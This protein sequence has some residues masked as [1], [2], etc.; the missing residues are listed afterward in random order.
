MVRIFIDSANS[1]TGKALVEELSALGDLSV[2]LDPTQPSLEVEGLTVI[3]AEDSIAM[4]Q[5]LLEHDVLVFDLH[6]TPYK[7]LENS[8]KFLKA[9]ELQSTKVF[10]CIS[11]VMVWGATK[12]KVGLAEGE[13]AEQPED[14]Q[15]EEGASNPL[16]G[17]QPYTDK[18]FSL[19]KAAGRFQQWK[20]LE[21]LLISIGMSRPS[22]KLYVMAAG[23]MYGLG[24]QIL[25]YHFQSAWLEDPMQLPYIGQGDNV[26]PTIHI[27]DLARACK[28]VAESKPE[29]R[30]IIAVDCTAL[31][32]QRNIV[33]SISKGVGTGQVMSCENSAEDWGEYLSMHTYLTTSTVLLELPK[34]EEEE[35]EEQDEEG[36]VKVPFDWHCKLGIPGNISVLNQEFVE[37]RGLVPVKVIVSGPPASGK[38]KFAKKLASFYNVPRISVKD[39]VREVKEAQTDLGTR[40]R[41]R[42]QELVDELQEAAE[43]D[44]VVNPQS[45]RIPDDLLAEAFRVR[46]QANQCRNRGYILDGWPRSYSDAKNLLKPKLTT[47]D[48]EDNEVEKEDLLTDILP[49]SLIVLEASD[50]FLTARVRDSSEAQL[51]NTHFNEVDMPVRLAKYRDNNHNARGLP[52]LEDF[53]TSHG[54]ESCVL[55]CEESSVQFQFEAMKIF[56]ERTG[57]PRN[58]MAFED[59]AEQERQTR[60]AAEEMKRAAQLQFEL[61]VEE[62]LEHERKS[63][64]LAS[65][66]IRLDEHWRRNRELLEQRAQPTRAYIAEEVLPTLTEGLLEACRKLPENPVMFLAEYLFANSH[67]VKK[68]NPSSL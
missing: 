28:F 44:V 36:K 61:E 7:R 14:D 64:N 5:A 13:E 1:Y 11:S 52:S 42:L 47:T 4:S 34:S 27:I 66:Q 50:E 46:L 59:L 49:Q 29:Q 20:S 15:E 57:K 45:V 63:K 17:L 10:I 8:A 25:N 26:V 67:R 2:T 9:Q 30:Y 58:Y 43:E 21:T 54:I 32:T 37:T 16:K 40:V 3:D 23:L 24:E 62:A 39:V 41:D 65:V 51:V 38:T 6:S 48:A 31:P 55:S 68:P 18:D 53:L 22:L 56:I 19:R 33:E 12:P 60:F 35:D